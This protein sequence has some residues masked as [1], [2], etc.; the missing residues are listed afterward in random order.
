MIPPTKGGI[1][2]KSTLL[3]AAVASAV[4][5]VTFGTAA[6]AHHPPAPPTEAEKQAAEAHKVMIAQKVAACGASSMDSAP[7]KDWMEN[8]GWR[9]RNEAV[10]K[11]AYEDLLINTPPWPSWMLPSVARLE[12]GTRFQMAFSAGQDN[13]H[14]GG[15][16]TFDRIDSV[17]EVR[18]DLAVMLAWKEDVQRVVTFEITKETLVLVGPI[19]PQIDQVACKVLPGRYSQF[20]L[21]MAPAERSQYMSVFSEIYLAQPLGPAVASEAPTS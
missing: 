18:E 17:E 7:A 6:A 8:Y 21:L 14:P 10:A 11:A 2:M 1:D 5:S 19:G 15:F 12:P 9:Y 13:Q 4:L 20:Q 16:G 3:R